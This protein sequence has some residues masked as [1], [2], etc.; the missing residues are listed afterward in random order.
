MIKQASPKQ[1]LLSNH[2]SSIHL[3]TAKEITVEEKKLGKKDVK[4]V[5][6]E[7]IRFDSTQSRN[8][9]RREP[10]KIKMSPQTDQSEKCMTVTT[11]AS[12]GGDGKKNKKMTKM[13]SFVNQKW[14]TLIINS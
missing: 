6:Y 10:Q 11:N 1:D 4:I 3:A 2:S 13:K 5:H 7:E 9:S 8:R 12:P 14:K